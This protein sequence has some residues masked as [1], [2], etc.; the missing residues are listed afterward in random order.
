MRGSCLCGSVVFE[1]DGRPGDVSLCHCSQCRRQ[2]G[3]FWAASP[4][5]PAHFRLVEDRGL[6]WFRASP[7]AARGFCSGCGAFLFWRADDR[8]AIYFA[9]GT[10]DEP[11]GI[12]VD[13][14]IF[15]GD[16]GDYY[17]V[18][19]PPPAPSSADTLHGAC[20]CGANRFS[21]PGPMGAVTACHCHQCR[22]LSG[23]FSAS[24]AADEAGINWQSRHQAEFTTPGGGVRGFCPGCGSSLW[25]RGMDGEFSLEAGTIDSPT[26]GRLAQ[27]IFMADKGDYYTI[28]DGLPQ[29]AGD[30]PPD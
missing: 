10:L 1:V 28:D 9:P 26:G 6:R 15:T 7:A 14:Q 20:L 25:F 29:F 8:E 27:H 19:G 13:R 22:K 30:C 4:V 3:H 23:H 16:A 21:L 12:T 11:S 17:S 24:F 5:P 18:S 2:S